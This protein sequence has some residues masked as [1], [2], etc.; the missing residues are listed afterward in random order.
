MKD[1]VLLIG[2]ALVIGG[3]W[4]IY[5]PLAVVLAGLSLVGVAVVWGLSDDRRGT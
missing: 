3:C 2:M 4:S 1:T 5:P